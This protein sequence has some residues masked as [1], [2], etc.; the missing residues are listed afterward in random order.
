M[1]PRPRRR[2]IRTEPAMPRRAFPVLAMLLCACAWAA[3]PGCSEKNEP[4]ASVVLYF[5]VDDAYARPIIAEFER[6][7]G[8]RVETRTDT[9]ATKTTGLVARLRLEKDK[10]VAD[11]FWS[12]EPFM[13]EQLAREG[14]LAPFRSEGL[15]AWPEAHR[16]PDHAWYALAERSRVL[17]F[18]TRIVG[19]EEAPTQITDL[20]DPR[21]KGRLAMA[22]PEFGTTRGHVSMLFALWGE[23]P[24]RRWL[25]ALRDNEVI[26][27]DGN[28]A[29]VRAVASGEAHVGLTDT[30]DVFAGQ[31][32]GW[33]ID[34]I[35]IRHDTDE[36]SL[37]V[38][39]I[40]NTV[41]RVAGGPNPGSAARLM[42][43]L[44]SEGVE[45]RLA[46]SDSHN[47]PV[48]P[49]L[50]PEFGTYAPPDPMPLRVGPIVDAMER[51]MRACREVLGG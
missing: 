40:P 25:G 14:V 26:L 13:T 38:M 27:L 9:E 36:H 22:R 6:Q 30:D 15:A 2:A 34:L 10:P 43:F 7:T 45:R 24:A 18:N 39:T 3:S 33:P 47:Y 12:S 5:T 19:A 31:R 16:S 37:G 1:R 46:Q 49:A 8:I 41:A 35:Y 17:V 32:Q 29:V 48:S 11:V 50:A 42:E 44:V 4:G 20:T 51:A 28:S 21:W 23:E